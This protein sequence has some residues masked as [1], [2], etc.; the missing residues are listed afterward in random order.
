VEQGGKIRERHPSWQSPA[1]VGSNRSWRDT[2]EDAAGE[3]FRRR[4]RSQ[5]S[6][7]VSNIFR[8][9]TGTLPPRRHGTKEVAGEG[10]AKRC[11]IP[12]EPF[13]IC[14][15]SPVKGL[16]HPF[17]LLADPQIASTKLAHRAIKIGKRSI[18]EALTKAIALWP[19]GLETM[20][21]QKCVQANELKAPV[22]RVG[23]AIVSKKHR[24]SR[25]LDHSPMCKL[26]GVTGRLAFGEWIQ[27]GARN[28]RRR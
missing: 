1:H 24:L 21:I 25:S 9:H 22:E 13:F 7:R 4:L 17:H 28:H 16:R 15:D 26:G 10:R 5:F 6:G 20:K 2:H 11:L 18:Q 27:G 23:Y 12:G 14:T 19:K 3:E 8:Y